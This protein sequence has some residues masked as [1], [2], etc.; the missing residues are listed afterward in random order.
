MTDP[1]I[2]K[3]VDGFRIQETDLRRQRRVLR[4]NQ[5]VEPKGRQSH[6]RDA[7]GGQ[8]RLT[9]RYP[10]A[11]RH[12]GLLRRADPAGARQTRAAYEKFLKAREYDPSY[13]Q[14]QLKAKSIEPM[15]ALAEAGAETSGDTKTPGEKKD[16]GR[17]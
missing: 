7:G 10:V 3:E 12:D 6:Q 4:A 9:D 16:D 15:L 1:P 11:G 17:R 2:G 5:D 8:A 14:A 13:K